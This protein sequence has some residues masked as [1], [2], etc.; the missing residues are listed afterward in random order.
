MNNVEMK[1]E[2]TIIG[3]AVMLDR[4]FRNPIFRFISFII[5]LVGVA[6]IAVIIDYYLLHNLDSTRL[7]GLSLVTVAFFL[8]YLADRSFYFSKAK[9]PEPYSLEEILKTIKDGKKFNLFQVLS[10]ESAKAFTY[11]PEGLDSTTTDLALAILSSPDMNF[12]LFRLG[13]GRE[14]IENYIKN[15]EGKQGLSEIMISALNSAIAENHHQIEIGDILYALAESDKSVGKFLID[16]KLDLNDLGNLIYWQTYIERKIQKE[17]QFIDPSRLRLTGGI[18]RDWAFGWT[19]FLKQFSVDITRQI[20]E[21]G[22][23][24]EIIGHE[25]EINEIKESLLRQNGG[26]AILVGEPGVGKRTA[27]LGFAKKVLEGQTFSQL[28]FEHIVQIDIDYLMAGV[29]NP[30][31]VTERISGVLSEVA[32]AGNIIMYIENIQNL[33]SSGD[34][35]KIDA[36]EVLIPFLDMENIHVLASCDMANFNRY[37]VSNTALMQRFT[38]VNV[39][40]PS[41]DEM[42]RILEDVIPHI[43]QKTKSVVSYEAIKQIV[44]DAEK[45][46][47]NIPNPEKSIN[48]LDSVATHAVIE[49][50]KTIIMPKDV[51]SYI[52][53]KYQ[54]PAG[55]ASDVEKEKLINLDKYLHES[56][57]GQNEAI[58]AVSNALR[59]ARAGV[60][61]GKKPIGTFLFL[62]PTG[63]GKT[64]TAKALSRAYF[65]SEGS[66]VRLDMSEYQNKEDIYRLIGGN[67]LGEELQGSLTTAIRENPF[68]LLLFDEIE[69]AHKDILDLFLQLLDEGFITDGFGRKVSFTNNIVI[70]TSNAGS[71]LIREAVR[72]SQDYES[73]KKALLEY[74]QQESIYRSEFL[75]RFTSVIVFSPLSEPEIVQVAGLMINRLKKT[76]IENKGITIAIDAPAVA[77]LAK[78]GY[79]PQMGA[80]PMERAIQDKVENLL[81]SKILSNELKKGDSITITANDIV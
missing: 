3:E 25:K 33:L 57:I 78:I 48:L 24:L 68:S 80:R 26:N 50:G 54:V 37:I 69:K 56:V 44:A 8:F 59:R 41:G 7:F 4:R 64:E 45:Y 62:G 38:R 51:D 67:V 23:N 73:V 46:I 5:W 9:R 47:Q 2:G 10:F 17:K 77:K 18:G 14:T 28:D 53:T 30:S 61:G 29:S 27:V 72:S 49:R 40:E 63:V 55:E 32:A 12:I 74:L 31:E 39:E 42:I 22:L 1:M 43:E 81:A 52:T 16:L 65:G 11:L 20:N 70:A 35:G 13:I 58:L 19:P 66:M 6:S 15:G 79:D 21:H 36:T 71:N 76:M 34:A 60:S 75:N